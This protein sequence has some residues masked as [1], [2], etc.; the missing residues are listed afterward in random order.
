MVGSDQRSIDRG[1][2]WVREGI[3]VRGG[4]FIG[5]N[6]KKRESGKGVCA[7][8]LRASQQLRKKSTHI[9]YVCLLPLSKRREGEREVFVRDGPCHA[10]LPKNEGKKERKKKMN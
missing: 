7:E 8:L 10:L 3:Q 9:F 4:T 2:R 1:I 5:E 6:G